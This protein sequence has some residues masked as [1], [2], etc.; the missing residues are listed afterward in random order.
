MESSDIIAIVAII[1]GSIISII[2]MTWTLKTSTRQ[3]QLSEAS[4]MLSKQP[5]L[6]VELEGGYITKSIENG[7]RWLY[8]NYKLKNIGDSPAVSIYCTCHFELQNISVNGSKRVNIDDCPHYIH[9]MEMGKEE[10]ISMYFENREIKCL[11]KDMEKSYDLNMERIKTNPSR[12]AY[13]STIAEVELYFSNAVGQW[14]KYTYRSEIREIRETN[15]EIESVYYELS[16]KR[17][18]SEE[19]IQLREKYLELN[20]STCRIPPNKLDKNSMYALRFINKHFYNSHFERIDRKTARNELSSY[21][22]NSELYRTLY[23][24][25]D[26]D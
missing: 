17:H 15:E 11:V 16:K 24:E 7:R 4:L 13:H 19:E 2:S 20:R 14:F 1:A 23:E 5:Y 9:A 3:N 21:E 22:G 10:S 6:I 25:N 26:V 18:T 12:E 8:I